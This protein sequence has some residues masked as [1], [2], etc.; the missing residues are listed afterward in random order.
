MN[1]KQTW[2]PTT[3]LVQIPFQL[4]REGRQ[5]TPALPDASRVRGMRILV[6]DDST[7]NRLMYRYLLQNLQCAVETCS[8]GEEAL[9]RTD[10]S[11]FGIVFLDKE[12]PCLSG[13]ETARVLR[14]RIPEV[15]LVGITGSSMPAQVNLFLESGVKEVLIKPVNV[16]IIV[17]TLLRHARWPLKSVQGGKTPIDEQ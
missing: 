16:D 4:A 13:P 14:T 11:T 7:S 5:S 17:K 8:N 1:S 15:P 10:L 3:F 12:M 9:K 2:N 6:V